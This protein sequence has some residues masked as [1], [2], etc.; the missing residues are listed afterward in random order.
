MFLAYM[1][2]LIS[3]FKAFVEGFD[4][5]FT[6]WTSLHVLRKFALPN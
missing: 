4:M 5:D 6:I 1:E 3:N 2:P